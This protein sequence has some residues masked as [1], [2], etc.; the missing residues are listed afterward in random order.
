MLRWK[1]LRMKDEPDPPRKYYTFKE[2]EYVRVNQPLSSPTDGSIDPNDQPID[3]NDL[4]RAANAGPVKR[5]VPPP[6]NEVHAML[7][8]NLAKADAA[9]LNALRVILRRK[10]K[11]RRDF[12]IMF[13]GGN[14]FLLPLVS[15]LLSFKLNAGLLIMIVSLC[16]GTIIYN[17][18]LF[19]IMWVVMDD[20]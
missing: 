18:G 9:G 7:R 16:A 8:D 1:P 14:G 10:S 6:E 20:Y 3:V 12:L 19:W 4:Y 17:I 5:P 13:F 11:R 2:S 15:L